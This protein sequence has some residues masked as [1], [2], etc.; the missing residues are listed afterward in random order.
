M[1][2]EDQVPHET[3]LGND[4]VNYFNELLVARLIED[5]SQFSPPAGFLDEGLAS[6]DNLKMTIPSIE[7][8]YAFERIGKEYIHFK[9]TRFHAGDLSPVKT[10][11]LIHGEKPLIKVTGEHGNTYGDIIET[12]RELAIMGRQLDYQRGD[13]HI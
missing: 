8:D 11:E 12:N 4:D 7:Y 13:S 3:P 6:E 10:I 9:I 2:E 1:E 5:L